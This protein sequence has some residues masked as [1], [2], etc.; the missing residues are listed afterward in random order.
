VD[1]MPEAHRSRSRPTIQKA[2]RGLA[3]QLLQ[4]A[5]VAGVGVET[6][7]DHQ[8]RIK[9]YLAEESPALRALVPLVADGYPVVVEVIGRITPLAQETR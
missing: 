3:R 4:H 7:A 8:E 5:G 9:V 2:K 1:V 6:T